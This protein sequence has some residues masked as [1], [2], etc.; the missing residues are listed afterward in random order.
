MFDT[1]KELVT[2]VIGSGG[3][4]T[5]FVEALEAELSKLKSLEPEVKRLRNDSDF[6]EC[7]LASGVDNWDGY[8]DAQVMHEEG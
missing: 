7:L 6:L 2:E 4:D 5:E 3:Y 8:Y 1:I